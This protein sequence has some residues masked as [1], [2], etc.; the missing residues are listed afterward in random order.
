MFQRRTVMCALG[1]AVLLAGCRES[2]VQSCQ[3]LIEKSRYEEAVKRC[4]E[5]YTAEGDARAGVSAVFAHYSLGHKDEVL[6]WVD[7]LA[8]D[9]KVRPGVW[10]LAAAVHEQRGE[11]ETAERE[12]RSDLTLYQAAGHHQRA[13]DTLN[14]LSDL[15]WNRSRY[16]EAFLF[17]SQAL[18]E[19]AATASRVKLFFSWS[20][21]Y[22]WTSTSRP[23]RTAS[24][25]V[26]PTTVCSKCLPP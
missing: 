17:A 4:A 9:G 21:D 19:A 8:K 1:L 3:D 20:R 5:V 24:P 10:G 25:P 11:A 2:G 16:R 15:S 18:E 14:R 13:A 23:V 22:L 6:N 12:Y 7:R 26:P